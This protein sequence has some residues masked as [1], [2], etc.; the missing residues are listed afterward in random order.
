MVRS[1]LLSALLLSCLSFPAFAADNA[2]VTE[3]LARAESLNGIDDAS[4]SPWHM[5]LTFELMDSKGHPSEQ[6]S[7]EQWWKSP[8]V[9]KIVFTSP[10]YS[11][12]EIQT[13]QALYRTKDAASSP[14][15]LTTILQEIVHP[16]VEEDLKDGIPE[17][18]KRDSG[19]VPLDCIMISQP[20][21]D[22]SR[23]PLGLFPTYCFDQ[24][25]DVLRASYNFGSQ[26]VLRNNIG[27][28]QK[29]MLPLN[30]VVMFNKTVAITAHVEDLRTTPLAVD[31][32]DT[33]GLQQLG[34]NAP[35]VAPGVI[36]GYAIDQP[37]PVL[38][39][40]ARVS[41]TVRFKARIG[42]DGRIHALKLTSFPDPDLAIASIAAVRQWIYK[43]YLLNGVPVEISTEI[44]VNF[45]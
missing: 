10:S 35:E 26:T 31:Q 16:L 37:Q 9:H 15:L 34:G 4:L 21:E 22:A 45:R 43:P 28:F 36:A 12:I 38:P 25:K 30:V 44:T 6:G 17:L 20:V 19:K 41:G 13:E 24:N 23:L 33:T 42:T 11:S 29:R 40:Y 1:H 32:F 18:R 39:K 8:S 5:K 14:Y 2:A 7:I 3:R 27:A